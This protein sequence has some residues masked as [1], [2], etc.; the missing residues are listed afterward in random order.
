DKEGFLRSKTSLIQ[1]MGRAARHIEGRVIM[2]ADHITKSMKEA[3]DEVERRRKIQIDYNLKNNITPTGIKKGIRERILPKVED[4]ERM[5]SFSVPELVT[6]D[7]DIMVSTFR[8]SDKKSQRET[9]RLLKMEMKNAAS[10]LDF[11]RAIEL[12]DILK[13][14]NKKQ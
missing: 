3:L 5:S 10:L 12:R 4:R 7:I 8:V 14:L 11:E 6:K 1:T 13:K 9:V 2:Y